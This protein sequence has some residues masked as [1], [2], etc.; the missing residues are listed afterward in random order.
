MAGWLA[1]HI[2]RV[3]TTAMTEGAAHKTL[4][5]PLRVNILW[6]PARWEEKTLTNTCSPVTTPR[7]K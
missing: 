2:G 6:V 5:I 3:T 4:H 7:R 1:W